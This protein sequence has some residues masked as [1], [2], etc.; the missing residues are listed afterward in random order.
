MRSPEM[1]AR[2]R[3]SAVGDVRDDEASRELYASDASIY[4]R[5][6]AATLRA[7]D[8]DDLDAAVEACRD[9]G[10]PLTMRGGGTS[11]AGQAIGRGLVV[12]CSALRE[13]E[14]DPGAR[15]A[16]V[17][18]GV[19]LDDLNRAAAAHGLAFGPDV[20]TASRATLGGM[21]ANNSAGA[22]SVVH[23][24]TADHAVALEVTLADG[25][26]ATL[27]RGAPAPAALEAA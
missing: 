19:V 20:A 2:L 13:I 17:G 24:L 11:L 4:R 16:R 23:G 8:A 10:I 1:V 18:P 15:V 26:R 21:I 14:I 27:R 6:P 25:A 22:R 7:H 5:L 12:D 3:R 9:T